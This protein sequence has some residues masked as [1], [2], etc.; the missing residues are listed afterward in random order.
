MVPDPE[1]LS[2]EALS[3]AALEQ[4]GTQKGKK[5]TEEEEKRTSVT[6]QST[7]PCEKGI[8]PFQEGSAS[9]LFPP[10]LIWD[11]PSLKN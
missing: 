8:H 10:R 3:L 6:Q 9:W 11:A 4:C 2:G 7:H 5:A 1:A